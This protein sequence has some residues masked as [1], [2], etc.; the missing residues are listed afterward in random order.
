MTPSTTPTATATSTSPPANDP[1]ARGSGSAAR[2]TSTPT[3][4]A[5]NTAS[6]RA[7][8]GAAVEDQSQ[9][10]P[11]M[12]E[13]DDF[14]DHRELEVRGRIVHR[15]PS[16]FR[17]E[18]EEQADSDERQRGGGAPPRREQGLAE[19]AAQREAAREENERDEAQEQGRFRERRERHLAARSHALEA[20]PRVEAR[21]HQSE[22]AQCEQVRERDK[23]AREAQ[24]RLAPIERQQAGRAQRRRDDRDWRQPEHPR[25]R[26][27]VGGPLAPQFAEVEVELQHRGA[28]A[29]GQPRL[30][31]GGESREQRGDDQHE[32]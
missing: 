17:Q 13:H 25:R 24:Q 27:A 32:P 30:R 28:A 18:N 19:H 2:G 26:A 31:L 1:A 21:Q 8:Q 23:I 7:L 11:A 22:A 4:R 12:V 16:V 3:S 9:L 20:R 15:H 10:G 29:T 5:P 14:V 6:F